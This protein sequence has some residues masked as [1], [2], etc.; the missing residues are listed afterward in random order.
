M[1]I[2]VLAI[3]TVL[4]CFQTS[5]FSAP[6]PQ[7]IYYLQNNFVEVGI[8][9][10]AGGV[11][12]FLAP[13][14]SVHSLI[15]GYDLGRYIQQSYYGGPDGSTWA[16]KPWTWNPVQGGSTARQPAKLLG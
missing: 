9:P 14:G 16:G 6:Q 4:T 5:S 1:F 15:N 3:I 2:R 7:L 10:N 8:N 11:I 12:S 13:K